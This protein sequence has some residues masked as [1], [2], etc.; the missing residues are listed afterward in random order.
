VQLRLC[1]YEIDYYYLPLR[2]FTPRGPRRGMAERLL[3]AHFERGGWT[4]WRGGCLHQLA[5]TDIYPNVKR[6]YAR[7]QAVVEQER[8]ES[9]RL[10][11]LLCAIHHGMPDF[12]V[13]RRGVLKFVECKLGHEQLG[14]YQRKCLPKLKKLG[15]QVE[16]WK[17]VDECTKT[18]RAKVNI[19]VA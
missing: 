12:I 15:F 1:H 2:R 4:V 13:Y 9:W 8:Q 5:A 10:L 6:K 19:P 18:R 17:V 11:Q 3:R 7:L 16:V 14:V